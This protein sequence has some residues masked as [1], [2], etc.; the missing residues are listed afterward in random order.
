MYT[1]KDFIESL[2][3]AAGVLPDGLASELQVGICNGSTT[4]FIHRIDLST[5]SGHGT[6]LA[7]LGHLHPG[8]TAVSM[9]AETANLDE[10]LR[11]LVEDDS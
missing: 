10:E 4:T 1:V 3:A 7:V 8:D 11:R 2:V 5:P 9:P 6:Y